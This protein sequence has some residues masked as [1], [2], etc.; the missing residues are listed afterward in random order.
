MTG[1]RGTGRRTSPPTGSSRKALAAAGTSRRDDLATAHRRHAGTE[2]VAAL[3]DEFRGLVGSLHGTSP[4]RRGTAITP[5]DPSSA[6]CETRI[7]VDLDGPHRASPSN[8]SRLGV[9]PPLEGPTRVA[10]AYRRRGL[11]SQSRRAGSRLRASTPPVFQFGA[12]G[13][14]SCA[15]RDSGR[16]AQP[17]LVHPTRNGRGRR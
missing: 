1:R 14:S 2:A 4:N 7:A 8:G 9:Q 13:L 11:A 15:T 16:G 3:A 5:A 6:R 12:P 17:C 10:A